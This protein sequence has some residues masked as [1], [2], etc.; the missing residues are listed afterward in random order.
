MQTG[1]H[2][3]SHTYTAAFLDHVDG[4]VNNDAGRIMGGDF[5]NQ[6]VLNFIYAEA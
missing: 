4:S 2:S 3:P 5:A 6:Y 1:T